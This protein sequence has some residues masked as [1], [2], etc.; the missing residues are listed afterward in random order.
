MASQ[1]SIPTVAL[2]RATAGRHFFASEK[3]LELTVA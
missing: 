2:A 3:I 1:F